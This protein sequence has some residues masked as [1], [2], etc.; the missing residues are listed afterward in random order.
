VAM[1]GLSSG[2]QNDE[3]PLV[4]FPEGAPPPP[5]S[6]QGAAPPQGANTSKGEPPH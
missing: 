6:K 2:C 3:I 4:K 1:A 5:P